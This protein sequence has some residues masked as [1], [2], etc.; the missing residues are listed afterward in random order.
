MESRSDYARARPTPVAS[1]K[2]SLELCASAAHIVSMPVL[3]KER[4]G[5]RLVARVSGSD[6]LLLQRAASLEG[7]SVATF[8]ITHAREMARRIV[9]DQETI[10]LDGVQSRRFVKALLNPTPSVPTRLKKGVVA[11]RQRVAA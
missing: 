5:E 4:R 1:G 7:R 3:T 6:K 8:V 10:E 9:A 11:Y 2:N